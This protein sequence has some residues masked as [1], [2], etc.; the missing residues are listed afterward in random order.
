MVVCSSRMV[1]FLKDIVEAMLVITCIGTLI[2][3]FLNLFILSTSLVAF[4]SWNL[5]YVI[6]REF[7]FS[8]LWSISTSPPSTYF[9]F[10]RFHKW[11]LAHIFSHVYPLRCL[12]EKELIMYKNER[13]MLWVFAFKKLWWLLQCVFLECANF[14]KK[15]DRPMATHKLWNFVFNHPPFCLQFSC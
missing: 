9:E 14:I 11:C 3:N 6:S 15:N 4:K 12:F 10:L 7:G 2:T 13:L 1:I 5:F 8:N